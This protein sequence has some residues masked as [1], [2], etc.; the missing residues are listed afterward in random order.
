MGGQREHF[1]PIVRESE[2]PVFH[3]R[4]E[5]RVLGISGFVLALVGGNLDAFRFA[6]ERLPR[7]VY[8]S[9]YYRRMLGG[10]ENLLVRIGYLGPDEV[11]ARLEGRQAAPSQ[12]RSSR[13]RLVA[14]TQAMRRLQRPTLPRWV[15]AHVLPRV[16][17]SSRPTLRRPRFMVGDSIRVRAHQAVGHTRQPGY[18]TGKPG[19][20]TAHLGA[21]LLPDAH[22]EFRRARP[23]HLYTVA[24]AG[25]DLWGEAA[26]PATEVRVDLYEPYLEPA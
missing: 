23:E 6:T 16:F 21:T 20:V 19:V 22:A 5:G 10:C 12:R 8:M 24:F 7:E 9:G 11:E 3:S 4:P 1:G 17:G 14:T 26:E 18:V 2:E 15:C 25:R 13:W